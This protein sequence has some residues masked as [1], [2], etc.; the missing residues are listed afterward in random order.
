V[1]GLPDLQLT[2]RSCLIEAL[3]KLLYQQI[4]PRVHAILATGYLPPMG[5]GFSGTGSSTYDL[6]R[7]A[8]V[9]DLVV[10]SSIEGALKEADGFPA[11]LRD[12]LKACLRADPQQRPPARLVQE[13]TTEISLAMSMGSW[14]LA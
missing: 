11:R 9:L 12:L 10:E 3:T 14:G 1:P 6:T 8:Y 5:P 2:T 13:E 4:L 7:G